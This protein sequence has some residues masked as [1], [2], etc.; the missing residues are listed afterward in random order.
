MMLILML[1]NFVAAVV[2]ASWVSL[3]SVVLVVFVA[4][5]ALA[6]SVVCFCY[7]SSFRIK[8]CPK[9]KKKK[10]TKKEVSVDAV[11]G[12]FDASASGKEQAFDHSSFDCVFFFFD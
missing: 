2:E 9:T 3:P 7:L 1:I 4:G 11:A 12:V 5:L 8:C 6:F 10:T